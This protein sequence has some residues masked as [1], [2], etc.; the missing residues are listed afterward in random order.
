MNTF[1]ENDYIEICNLITGKKLSDAFLLIESY[2]ESVQNPDI[3]RNFEKQKETYHYLLTYT[4]QGIEDPE[5]PKIY[6]KIQRAL[7]NITESIRDELFKNRKSNS[8]AAR[9]LIFDKE[10][11]DNKILIEEELNHLL[12]SNSNPDNESRKGN[13]Y[14]IFYLLWMTDFLNESDSNALKKIAANKSC[15]FHEKSVLVS[16]VTISLLRR[17]DSAKFKVLFDFYDFNE[18]AVWNRAFVGILMGFY[19][20]NNRVYLFDEL[21]AILKSISKDDLIHSYTENIILQFIRSKETEKISKK[22][23]DE[24]IPE[25]E[26]FKPKIQD[27]LN[28]DEII[29]DSLGEDKNPDWEEIF[30][31][32]PDLLNKMA[33]FSKLQLEGSDVFMSAFAMFKK[34]PFFKETANWFMPFYAENNEVK[35]IFSAFEKSFDTEAFTE[36][37]ERSVF[38]CN[39]DK[40]SFCM[41]VKMMPES[42]RNMLIELFKTEM[43]QMKEIQK[44][45]DLL[46]KSS[47]DTYIFRRYIQDLYRFFKLHPMHSD[48][49]DFFDMKLDMH[50]SYFFDKLIVDEEST[51]K[52]AELYFKKGFYDDAAELLG[53]LKLEGNKAKKNYEKIGFAYQ[54]LNNY[55]KALDFYLKA[56]LFG[57]PSTWLI[58]KIAFCHRKMNNYE[59][60]LEYYRFAESDDDQNLHIQ[61]NIGHCLLSLGEYDEALKTYFK[62]E[63]YDPNNLKAMRPIA[64]CS[65][66]LGKFDT[67][68]KYFKKIMEGEPKAYDF[69][70]YGHVLFCKGDK[71]KSVDMYLKALDFIDIGSFEQSINQDREYLLKHTI[72]NTDI[73][74]LLDY[75][76]SKLI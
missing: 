74:L 26:K 70:N 57:E 60:A 45:D 15:A 8:L 75:I 1:F 69:I 32:S 66:V 72:E 25:M 36:G 50:N 33:D 6:K 43:E 63:Y 48:F 17:F 73:D 7:I 37:L 27:K 24:I 56:E 65:F 29:S 47:Q 53:R 58:R 3:K 62:V 19:K 46:N 34:F 23:R 38:M 49:D 64:W 31:D 35:D 51:E 52:I 40:Y 30:D 28:L 54:K 18:E 13:L 10:V 21:K 71:M 14:K 67:A 9:K 44:D 61:A 2:I 5:K 12:Q 4:F 55:I 42:Q 59:K 22:L 39:S 16:A 20:Y 41:N 68:L 11:E 76:K